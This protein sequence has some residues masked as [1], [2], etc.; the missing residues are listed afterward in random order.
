[1]A[2]PTQPASIAPLGE[3]CWFRTKKTWKSSNNKFSFWHGRGIMSIS[4]K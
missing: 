2:W 4:A 1:V 3:V